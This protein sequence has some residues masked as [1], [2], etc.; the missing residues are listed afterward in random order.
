MWGF[1]KI[2]VPQIIDFNRI[3]PYK[4]SIFGTTIFR[5]PP[6][7]FADL[8]TFDHIS[9]WQSVPLLRWNTQFLRCTRQEVYVISRSFHVT[10]N[11]FVR[12]DIWLANYHGSKPTMNHQHQWPQAPRLDNLWRAPPLDLPPKRKAHPKECHHAS[13]TF[14]I[15]AALWVNLGFSFFF[16]DIDYIGH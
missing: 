5:K 7:D 8:S 9:R 13:R 1:P 10:W 4:P 16:I 6:C 11:C 15:A 2:G 3:F 12:L 14:E